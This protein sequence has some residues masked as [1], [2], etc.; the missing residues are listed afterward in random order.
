M[1]ARGEMREDIDTS[2]RR[3]GIEPTPRAVLTGTRVQMAA[4]YAA[5][6]ADVAGVEG[7]EWT[8]VPS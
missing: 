3:A 2:D 7:Y 6:P 4:F 1:T 8:A 5:I